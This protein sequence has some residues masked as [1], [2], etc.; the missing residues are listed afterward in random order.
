MM[1]IRQ[2]IIIIKIR[3]RLKC[4]ANP[5]A[6]RGQ[7][8]QRDRL[9]RYAFASAHPIAPTN[10][11]LQLQYHAPPLEADKAAGQLQAQRG[12]HLTSWRVLP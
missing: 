6:R 3:R 12:G 10:R 1:L 2:A 7:S 9:A 8:G 4:I 11:R 5:P